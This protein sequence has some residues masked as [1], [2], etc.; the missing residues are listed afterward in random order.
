[1]KLTLRRWILGQFGAISALGP[2]STLITPLGCRPPGQLARAKAENGS[3]RR[4]DDHGATTA[5]DRSDLAADHG[6]GEVPRGDDADHADRL[7]G[8]QKALPRQGAGTTS[9]SAAGFLANQRR[10]LVPN[11]ISPRPR[12]GFACSMA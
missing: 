6:R 5:K 7:A 10:K 1:V 11:P 8:D 3:G 12:Q 4:L 2:V 9:H